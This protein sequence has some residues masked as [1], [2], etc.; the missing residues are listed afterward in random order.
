MIHK[1]F[2][3]DRYPWYFNIYT[4]ARCYYF[5]HNFKMVNYFLLQNLLQ[6]ISMFS[7]G[8]AFEIAL[9]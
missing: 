3:A 7:G 9:N 4:A 2:K 1:N 5:C 6:L 8:I